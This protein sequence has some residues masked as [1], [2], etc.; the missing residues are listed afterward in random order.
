MLLDVWERRKSLARRGLGFIVDAM[1]RKRRPARACSR[2][3]KEAA[4]AANY[5][6]ETFYESLIET[7]SSNNRGFVGKVAKKNC[8]EVD[9]RGE[10]VVY[11]NGPSLRSKRETCKRINYTEPKDDECLIERRK[12]KPLY[13]VIDKSMSYTKQ[14]VHT[15][16]DRFPGR[17]KPKVLSNLVA[18]I[19]K[20][21]KTE[22][23]VLSDEADNFMFPRTTRDADTEDIDTKIE[24]LNHEM[25]ESASTGRKEVASAAPPN[26]LRPSRRKRNHVNASAEGA[27]ER[28]PAPHDVE[29]KQEIPEIPNLTRIIGMDE[30]V[31][32]RFAFERVPTTEPWYDAFLRQDEGRERVFEYYGSTAYRKLPFEMGPLPPLPAN[33]CTLAACSSKTPAATK[34]STETKEEPK[35]TKEDPKAVLSAAKKRH[36]LDTEYPRKSPR[37]HA[38]TLAILSCL[39]QQR[40]K[41]ES[42]SESDKNGACSDGSESVVMKEKRKKT[43]SP[44]RV[45]RDYVSVAQL[46]REIEELLSDPTNE[47]FESV[48]LSVLDAEFVP[49]SGAMPDFV[50]LV[51]TAAE[52]ATADGAGV[53]EC[54]AASLAL[55]N[56]GTKKRKNNRTGWPKCSKKAR[57]VRKST[58]SD[59][60]VNVK[61][62]DLCGAVE[63][64]SPDNFTVSSSTESLQ[65]GAL[66]DDVDAKTAATKDS[67][68][69]SFSAKSCFIS[70]DPEEVNGTT[71]PS[72]EGGGG[73]GGKTES[74]SP[75]SPREDDEERR[76]RRRNFYQPIIAL[77]RLD[78]QL[79]FNSYSLR[80]SAVTK[81]T[82]RVPK[83]SPKGRKTRRGRKTT[84]R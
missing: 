66:S 22:L 84:Y 8:L 10:E 60:V 77:N 61:S 3:P 38:S 45:S 27:T 40:K 1:T 41:E 67:D 31:R 43:A 35:K 2:V 71:T 46:N 65:S 25:G 78:T 5:V 83:G 23:S 76:G 64:V 19:K 80:S 17:P 73:G 9:S 16:R 37:E 20:R 70:D 52:T 69:L 11:E 53:A 6:K 79:V 62:E 18:K 34:T 54:A 55:K 82:K 15:G 57:G 4:A 39:V 50:D 51:A 14:H 44:K 74:P 48:D 29:V 33:C 72:E 13:K 56:G 42:A 12:G 47:S 28:H 75:L 58:N 32:H 7:R 36:L 30:V 68:T 49:L 81:E 59:G 21:R 26:G 63:A 24:M